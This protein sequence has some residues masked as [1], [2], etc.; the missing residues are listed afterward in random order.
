MKNVTRL[1]FA[2]LLSSGALL[3]RPCVATP[4]AWDFTGSLNTARYSHSATLLQDGRVLVAG[5]YD[6]NLV[7][8][9]S[10]ELYDPATGSWSVT[11]SLNIGRVY[12]SAIL[13]P[14]GKVLV[15]GGLS[16]GGLELTAEL[17]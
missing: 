11:R 2:L 17:Y 12:Q 6:T 4:G 14:N 13:L 15:V 1:I 10:A 9:H 16:A 8:T 3:A 5:G 7:R